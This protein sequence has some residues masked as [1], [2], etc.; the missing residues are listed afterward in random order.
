MDF[1]ITTYSY[2]LLTVTYQTFALVL[3]P[4]VAWFAE[5][6]ILG[7]MRGVGEMG[8]S[9]LGTL[10]C[11]IDLKFLP[12]ITINLRNSETEWSDLNPQSPFLQ[13]GLVCSGAECAV[14]T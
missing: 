11:L 7:I 3:T 2:P 6:F 5:I 14:S 9:R 12:V 8:G 10:S 13:T 1:V 4:I